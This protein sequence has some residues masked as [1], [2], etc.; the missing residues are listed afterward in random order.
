[1]I[2]SHWW[3]WGTDVRFQINEDGTWNTY[4]LPGAT[5]IDKRTVNYGINDKPLALGVCFARARKLAVTTDA[6][7]EWPGWLMVFMM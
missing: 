5:I 4:Y 2:Y 1:M 6:C 3:G 7:F